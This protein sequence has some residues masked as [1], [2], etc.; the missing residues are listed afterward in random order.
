MKKFWKIRYLKN[1]KNNG[2]FKTIKLFKFF[3]E[4][5]LKA[6]EL[7]SVDYRNDERSQKKIPR[8]WEPFCNEGEKTGT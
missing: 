2:T 4:T 1:I 7:E 8:K 3:N 5:Y 6:L